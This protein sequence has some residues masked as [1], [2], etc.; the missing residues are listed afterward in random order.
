V[1]QSF[2]LSP[3]GDDSFD[4]S[5]AELRA[6]G[7]GRTDRL[8][9]VFVDTT[10]AGICGIASQWHDDKPGQSNRNNTGPAYARVDAAA[11]TKL[12]GGIEAQVNVENV[13]GAAYFP[14][15]HN[16][17]NIAPGGPRTVKATLRFGL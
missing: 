8:Y 5:I 14:T 6:Q 9:L 15:A 1:T 3:A 10:A 16:D 13:F 12:T 7:Y 4:N 17:N 11:F 2:R